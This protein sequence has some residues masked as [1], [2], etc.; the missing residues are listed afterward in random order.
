MYLWAKLNFPALIGPGEERKRKGPS[1]SKVEQERQQILEEMKK[2][3]QLLTDNSW[4]RQRSASVYKEPVYTG[5]QLKRWVWSS[6]A[7]HAAVVTFHPFSF[8]I[9]PFSAGLILWTTWILGDRPQT[10]PLTSATPAHTPLLLVTVLPVGTPHPAIALDLSYP[11]EMR[12]RI[13]LMMAGM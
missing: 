4:I 6:V 10:Q 9:L 13:P 3:T 1:L 7:P 12:L 8:D 5:V 11:R 2:R